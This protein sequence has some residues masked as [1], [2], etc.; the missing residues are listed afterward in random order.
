MT[1]GRDAGFADF[2]RPFLLDTDA[3]KLRLGAMLSQKQADS[4]YHLVAYAIITQWNRS[5]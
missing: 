3:S 2:N 1:E 5:F 4:Q